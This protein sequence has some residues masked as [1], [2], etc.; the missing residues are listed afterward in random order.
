MRRAAPCPRETLR[1][2]SGCSV[3]S[4]L[5]ITPVGSIFVPAL[6]LASTDA[7]QPARGQSAAPSNRRTGTIVCLTRESVAP[8]AATG[9]ALSMDLDALRA[10]LAATPSVRAEGKIS[11]VTGLSLS[12]TLPGARVGDVVVVRRRGEP[13][14]AEVVGFHDGR[15]VAMPLGETTGVGPDDVV[16]STGAPLEVRTGEALLG[17]VLDGLGRAIDGK[18]A[19]GG[20]AAPVDRSP[21]PALRRARVE[22][23]MSTGFR[24]IDGLPTLANAHRIGLYAGSGVAKTTLLGSLALSAWADEVV[25]ALV[26]E[27]GREVREFVEQTLGPAR[28]RERSSSSPRATPPPSNASAPRKWPPR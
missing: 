6:M 23:A 4:G 24:A 14:L 22:H 13:L 7:L 16:E 8:R 11:G 20:E 10:E 12:A 1:Y 5:S 17:R 26:V 18:P 19:P 2:R 15:V 3:S 28:A 27:R 21:P 25:V 9:Q